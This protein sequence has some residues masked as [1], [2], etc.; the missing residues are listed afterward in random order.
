MRRMTISDVVGE[1]ES[2]RGPVEVWAVA[3]AAYDETQSKLV[4]LLA[5]RCVR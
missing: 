2:E 1:F 5:V 3:E 4:I